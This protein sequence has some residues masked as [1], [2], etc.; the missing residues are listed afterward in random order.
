MIASGGVALADQ[1]AFVRGKQA[2]YIAL[3]GKPAYRAVPWVILG[4]VIRKAEGLNR[5]EYTAA[6]VAPFDAALA[7]ALAVYGVAGA[8]DGDCS[9]AAAA[10]RAAMAGLVKTALA[11]PLS[12]SGQVGKNLQIANI[13]YNGFGTLT[14]TSSNTAVCTVSNTGLLSPKSRGTAVI[15][16]GVAE[17][18]QKAVFAMTVT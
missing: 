15:T 12:M 8:A 4:A 9:A 18:E 13:S 6:S 2:E 14:Y 16:V 3:A 5:Y 11:G 17:T 10:L 7:G 1:P